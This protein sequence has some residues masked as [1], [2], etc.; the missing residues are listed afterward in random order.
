MTVTTPFSHPDDDQDFAAMLAEA[1]NASTSPERLMALRHT[2]VGDT[3]RRHLLNALAAHPNLPPDSLLALAE[4]CPRAFLSNPALPLLPLEFPD[5]AERLSVTALRSLLRFENVPP[6]LLAH[7][8]KHHSAKVR[9]QARWHIGIAGELDAQATDW[10]EPLLKVLRRLPRTKWERVW[11]IVEHRIAPEGLTE[12]IGLAA[13]YP[14]IHPLAAPF[15]KAPEKARESPT[16]VLQQTLRKE[17]VRAIAAHP[18]ADA[19]LLTRIVREEFST[20]ALYA[21][22][23]NDRTPPTLAQEAF[24]KLRR[25]NDWRQSGGS[26]GRRILRWHPVLCPQGPL[27]PEET[28]EALPSYFSSQYPGLHGF[29]MTVGRPYSATYQSRIVREPEWSRRLA[30]AL[31]A[32]ATPAILKRLSRDG[33]R[34]VRVVATARLTEPEREILGLQFSPAT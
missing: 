24:Q 18:N 5:F 12:R 10:E 33:N 8:R 28:G 13:V 6:L 31:N 29:L 11:E 22:L 34:W 3:I 27:L 9:R 7:S 17:N 4:E 2:P 15:L 1:H 30:L 21:V 16:D 14:P 25:R 26:F 32:N 23:G 19:D 20:D